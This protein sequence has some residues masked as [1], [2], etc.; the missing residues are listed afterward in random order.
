MKW[1]IA[2]DIH[3]SAYYCNRLME[4]YGAEGADRLLLLGDILYHGPRNDLPRDY[5]PREVIALLNERKDEIFCVRG[6]C[7]AEVDDMVLAFPVRSDMLMISSEDRMIVA[8]HGHIY[9]KEN[10]PSMRQ[11]DV[12]LYGHSHIPACE[13]CGGVICMNPGSISIPKEGSWHGYMVWEDQCFVWKDAEGNEKRRFS[14]QHGD[15]VDIS[16]QI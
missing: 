2:S 4:R 6:N 5:A 1:M 16:W 9:H 11:G 8:T 14:L 12:L 13:A 3:G 10:L 7:D 15:I